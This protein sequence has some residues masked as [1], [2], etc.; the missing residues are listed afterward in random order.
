MRTGAIVLAAG[1]S[2]RFGSPKQLAELDGRPL[3]AHVLDAVTAVPALDPVILVLGAHHEPIRERVDPGRA[4]VALCLGWEE[5]MAAS[6]RAGLAAATAE[7]D[8]DAV[9][10]V[11][12][13]TPRLETD[14][15]R[16]VLAA[17]RAAPPAVPVRALYD[18]RPG[19]PVVLPRQLF[20]AVGELTGDEGARELLDGAPVVLVAAGGPGGLDVDTPESLEAL[21]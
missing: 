20:A 18:G 13:D 15:V 9:L 4:Q 12:G 5:G 1:A 2:R 10:V 17:A 11:L 16:E 7:H 19:H 21:R 3:L 8:L 14:V 6:L